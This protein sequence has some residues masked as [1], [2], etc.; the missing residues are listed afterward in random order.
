MP[1]APRTD[2]G[3]RNYRTGLLPWIRRTGGRPPIVA[4]P[5]L[6]AGPPCGTGRCVPWA[7]FADA[8]SPWPDPFPPS[9][10][11]PMAHHQPCSE[12]SQVLWA[13]PTSRIRSSPSFSF[14]IH[15]ADLAKTKP[16]PGSPGFRTE[17]ICLLVRCLRACMGSQT[18]RSP[19]G[20][21]DGDPPGVAFQRSEVVGTPDENVFEA[22]YPA[23]TYPCQRFESILAKR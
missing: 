15:G 6:V 17:V 9:P 18:T 23:R 20:S 21:R 22:Q 1:A 10:P 19:G 12:T 4:A 8:A 14:R 2:P 11:Q 16:N 13:C 5:A 3:E 7:W